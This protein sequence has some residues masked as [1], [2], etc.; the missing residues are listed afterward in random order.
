MRGMAIKEHHVSPAADVAPIQQKGDLTIEERLDLPTNAQPWNRAAV[1]TTEVLPRVQ[2]LVAT[3]AHPCQP[4]ALGPVQLAGGIGHLSQHRPRT[5]DDAH[6][7]NHRSRH[8]GRLGVNAD[9]SRVPRKEGRT[10]MPQPIVDAR[11]DGQDAVR[12]GQPSHRAIE[13]L[14]RDA[15]VL[16]QRLLDAA[17]VPDVRDNRYVRSSRKT[18]ERPPGIGVKGA[19][20]QHHKGALCLGQGLDGPPYLGIVPAA[21]RLDPQSALRVPCL[22][23]PDLCLQHVDRNRQMDGPRPPADGPL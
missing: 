3:G 23:L 7:G 1:L 14:V 9:D 21:A 13:H 10:A 16:R 4:A 19:A 20:A 6:I 22:L 8:F 18:G 11:P 2:Q 5:T 15:H 12:L 17:P